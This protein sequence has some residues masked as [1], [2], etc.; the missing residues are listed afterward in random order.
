MS[1]V[2]HDCIA[3]LNDVL[4]YTAITGQLVIRR[5]IGIRDIAVCITC[6]GI[7]VES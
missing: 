3:A 4:D 6:S 2:G 5:R 7:D 1:D